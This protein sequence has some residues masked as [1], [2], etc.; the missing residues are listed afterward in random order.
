MARVFPTHYFLLGADL[1]YSTPSFSRVGVLC[2]SSAPGEIAATRTIQLWVSV[3][4]APDCQPRI[5]VSG[6]RG[7][8]RVWRLVAR[9][10]RVGHVGQESTNVG[11]GSGLN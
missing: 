1:D 11:D 3:S 10:G 8:V 5:K 7:G 2:S 9:T 4:L 6:S